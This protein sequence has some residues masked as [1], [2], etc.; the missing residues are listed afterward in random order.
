M[1]NQNQLQLEINLR[2]VN[3]LLVMTKDPQ[4]GVRG[5]CPSISKINQVY[6][7]YLSCLSLL[8]WH[9]HSGLVEQ[10]RVT[11]VCWVNH[12]KSEAKTHG[13]RD[14]HSNTFQFMEKCFIYIGIPFPHHDSQALKPVWFKLISMCPLMG[15]CIWDPGMKGLIHVQ[16]L[17]KSNTDCHS[18]KRDW[19]EF[20]LNSP[21]KWFLA[22]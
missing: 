19:W 12:S 10:D 1:L 6:T 16:C 2:L 5:A 20:K 8:I 13:L 3:T 15:V 22:A 11:G 21:T 17:T 9:K 18:N 7:V 4:K 14:S